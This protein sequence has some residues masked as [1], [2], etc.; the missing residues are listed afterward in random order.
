MAANSIAKLAV[1]ITGDAGPLNQSMGQASNTVR[2]FGNHAEHSGGGLASLVHGMKEAMSGAHASEG[3]FK[4]ITHALLALATPQGAALIA[5]GAFVLLGVKA[6]EAADQAAEARNKIREEYDKAF[7]ALHGQKSG[8]QMEDTISGSWKE[9]KEAVADFFATFAENTGLVEA[10][11]SLFK[12]LAESVK[13]WADYMKTDVQKARE[14]EVAAMKKHTEQL[15]EAKKQQEENQKKA[16]EAEKAIQRQLEE[17][18]KHAERL[19]ASLRMP[20]EIYRDTIIELKDLAAQGFITGE[21]LSRGMKKA[22]DDLEKALGLAKEGGDLANKP[23]AAAERQTMAGYSAV[24]AARA[25]QENAAAKD[26]AKVAKNSEFL[27]HLKSIDET[28]ARPS[29]SGPTLM[30]SNL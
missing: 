27:K 14:R 25:A 5:A 29:A 21:T 22:Q 16:E 4:G 3:S 12:G 26:A 7:E 13:S 11:I 23:I 10:T 15:K 24:Q 6:L 30:V 28:L 9:A 18:R 17:T 8:V 1:I 19:T 2:N 20:D